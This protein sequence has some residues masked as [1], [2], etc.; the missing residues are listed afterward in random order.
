MP[1]V[2][3][4]SIGRLSFFGFG[5]GACAVWVD[6]PELL[7]ELDAQPQRAANA[8]TETNT[9]M[10]DIFFI[11]RTGFTWIAHHRQSCSRM[12]TVKLSLANH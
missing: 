2:K 11:V 12:V 3:R 4:C 5:G 6:E 10:V 9:L 8:N 7:L 1:T